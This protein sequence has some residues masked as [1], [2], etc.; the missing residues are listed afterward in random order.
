M[1]SQTAEY[2]LRACIALAQS[3]DLPLTTL[4]IARRT[5]VPAG[6]L[7]KVL[8]M[9]ARAR[10]IRAIRGLHG[11]YQ[12]HRSAA[13]LKILDVINAVD[14]I[15]RIRTCP[16][17]LPEHGACLCPLH[18]RMDNALAAVESALGASTLAEILSE[19]AASIPLCPGPGR[20]ELT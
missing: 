9:L 10:L 12:L 11:G 18:R 13:L 4:E 6:Y 2:A 15:R 8:Q 16:L 19:P 5:R 20:G 14:P 1:F 7:S 3:P 17:D